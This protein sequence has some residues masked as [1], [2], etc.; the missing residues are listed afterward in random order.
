MAS[1]EVITVIRPQDKTIHSLHEKQNQIP[2]KFLPGLDPEWID[3]WT[4]HGSKIIPAS[5]DVFKIQD[6]KVPVSKPKGS[7]VCRVYTPEGQGPFPVHMNMHGGGWV[8]GGLNSEQAWCRQVCNNVEMV[9][10]DV[11]YRLAPEYRFPV[12]IFDCWECLSW[13]L[14]NSTTLNID[15]ESVSIGG[16]SAGGQMAAVLAHFARDKGIKLKLQLLTVPA[17]DMRYCPIV[18]DGD[19]DVEA[20]QYESVKFCADAPWGPVGRESW[21]LNYFIGTESCTRDGILHDWM[22]TPVLAP[23]FKSLAPAFIVT[24]EFDVERDEGE[25]YGRLMSEAGNPVQ[26]KRYLGVPHAFAHYNCPTKGLSKAHE[27]VRDTCLVL[28]EAHQNL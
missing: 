15:P 9:V 21:F 27:Y 6:W 22:M 26:I 3:L 16:L 7:I 1:A 13:I 12:A 8:L 4:E 2:R 23:N 14:E 24:A 10:V 25:Y 28:K 20:C 17:T 5:P 18:V 19:L 11:E